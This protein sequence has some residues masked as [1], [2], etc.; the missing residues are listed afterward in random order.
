M[1]MRTTLMALAASGAIALTAC[2]GDDSSDSSSTAAETTSTAAATI[3]KDE[4]IKQGNEICVAGN[5]EIDASAQEVF[6]KG[7]KPSEEDVAKFGTDTV[8]PSVQSQIDAIRALGAPEGDEEVI[9]QALDDAQSGV[10]QINEDPSSVANGPPDLDKGAK[11]LQAY[12]LTAC[13]G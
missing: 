11:E 12:G 3:T 2:G 1:K 6:S 10:D 5:K 8:A 7:A 13:G 4:F 9:T